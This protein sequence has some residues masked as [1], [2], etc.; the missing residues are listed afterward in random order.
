MAG[1]VHLEAAR[2]HGWEGFF[3]E[4]ILWNALFGILFWEEL[5]APIPGAFQHRFQSAPLDIH[6]PDFFQKRAA[7][8]E[9]RFEEIHDRQVL[10]HRV[11]DTAKRKWGIANAFVSW[12]HLTREI[13]AAAIERIPPTVIINVLRTMAQNPRTFSSGFP[14]LFLFKPGTSAW[15]LWEVKGPG[16]TLRPEQERW[17]QQFQRLGCDA[18]VAWVKYE[19]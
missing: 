14:D 2:T 9:K 5:F 11:L 18:R 1:A 6:A 7:L 13:L 3:A 19:A 10:I 8:F 15:A 16:D 17:L 4:N 12:R